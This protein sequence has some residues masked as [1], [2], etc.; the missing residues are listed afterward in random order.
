MQS[1]G[2]E[3]T[4]VYFAH[5]GEKAPDGATDLEEDAIPVRTIVVAENSQAGAGPL[6]DHKGLLRQRLDGQPG[7][8]YLFRPDQHL[9]ARWR[10]FDCQA[11]R[12]AVARATMQP[13]RIVH[14]GEP[15]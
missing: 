9:A 2:K 1:I 13:R 7:T 3:F 10:E 8:Y 4:G 15:V 5:D 11:V 6:I 12:D 14:E